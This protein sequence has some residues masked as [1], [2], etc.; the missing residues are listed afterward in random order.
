MEPR[1][2]TGIRDERLENAKKS[3]HSPRLSEYGTLAKL[4]AGGAAGS[5][6]PNNKADKKN[7]SK[8]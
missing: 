3:Y 5:V 2:K 7:S 4:T 1:N 8:P 6:E